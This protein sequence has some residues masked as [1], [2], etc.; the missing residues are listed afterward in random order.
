MELVEVVE[1]VLL[2]KMVVDVQLL[3]KEQVE[4]VKQIL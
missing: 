1:L 4:Q 2:D 3:I